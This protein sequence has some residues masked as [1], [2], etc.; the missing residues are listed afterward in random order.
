M[1]TVWQKTKDEIKSKLHQKAFSL[2][3][4]PLE[5]IEKNDRSLVI[6]C[7]NKFSYHWVNENYLQLIHNTLNEIANCNVDLALK[8]QASNKRPATAP[9]IPEVKQLALPSAPRCVNR[10]PGSNR[11]FLN[12]DF[13][14]NRFVVGSSNA[15]AYSASNAFARSEAWNYQTLLMLAETGM[16]K[17]HLSQAV[18]HYILEQKPAAKV[19]YTTAE[20]FTNEMVF[21]I[22]NKRIDEFKNKYRRL[23]DVLLLE[24]IHF[25]TG[26]EKTQA[27]LGYT[28]DALMNDKKKVVFTSSIPPKNIPR[29]SK[30]LT[31][32]LTAGLITTIDNPDYKTRVNIISRKSSEQNL[33]LSEEIIDFL[34]TCLKR[35]IRQIESVIN[36]L[37]AKSELLNAKINLR[38]A[39]EVV[40]SLVSDTI[41]LTLEQIQDVVS[42]Y[43]KIRHEILRS[44]SRK[45]AHAYPRNIYAYLARLHTD[46]TLEKIGATIHRSHSAVIYA[47][48]TVE[49]KIKTDMKMKREVNFLSQKIEEARR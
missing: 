42:R 29:I 25:L 48:E 43:F 10:N 45:K 21:S 32:R 5:L 44:K 39:K 26:K 31:S 15:F 16:G 35:D 12:K 8:V 36:C 18:G 17:T 3:I 41:S 37:K 33:L 11:L 13:K 47:S 24:E 9:L 30:E 6:G 23:C 7:P 20:N 14:F 38:L 40:S 27:E 1:N 34:A 4:S 19:Y 46:E 22:K 49:H 28:L 2:W